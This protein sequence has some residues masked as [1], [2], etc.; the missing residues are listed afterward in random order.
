MWAQPRKAS[1][2]CFP[3]YLRAW[4]L[5]PAIY[6]SSHKTLESNLSRKLL[7]VCF[8]DNKIFE[9][10]EDTHCSKEFKITFNLP[11]YILSLFILPLVEVSTVYTHSFVLGGRKGWFQHSGPNPY[12]LFW[13]PN[14]N[15]QET[16]VK[17]SCSVLSSVFLLRGAHLNK[18]SFIPVWLSCS[19]P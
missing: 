9:E 15:Q 4:L 8:R 16:M 14:T 1:E 19:T 7:K 12:T 3:P 18:D 17:V 11:I 5:H 10:L 13:N 6:S 2:V